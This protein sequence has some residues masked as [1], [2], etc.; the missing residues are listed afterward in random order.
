MKSCLGSVMSVLWM[1]SVILF[2]AF[3]ALM[4]TTLQT[5]FVLHASTPWATTYFFDSRGGSI[6]FVRQ[7]V[8]H[9]RKGNF[10]P[11]TSELDVVNASDVHGN[12]LCGFSRA[13]GGPNYAGFQMTHYQLGYIL[14]PG[15]RGGVTAPG[16]K[17]LF[18]F[19]SW[20]VGVPI[21]FAL[22]FA[23][24]LAGYR[25]LSSIFRLR[26]IPPGVCKKCGYDLRAT[27]QQCP[28]CGTIVLPSAAKF[29][30]RGSSATGH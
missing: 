20:S 13:G 18:I 14:P 12:R 5:P 4:V 10:I 2:A 24:G 3:S 16:P 22:L 29:D 27:P 30:E 11:D 6:R 21:W 1:P 9:L 23:A 7:A 26:Q 25:E 28:E 17:S 8:S 19:D 15:T